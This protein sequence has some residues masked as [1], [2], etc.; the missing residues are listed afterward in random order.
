MSRL[1]NDVSGFWRTHV[2]YALK[3]LTVSAVVQRRI[4]V[5]AHPRC[6]R[7]QEAHG[8]GGCSTTY[9]GSGA[10]TLPTPSRVSRCRRLFNDVSGF[11]R[12]HVAHALKGLGV[13]QLF[14][15]VGV[16]W[17]GVT[18]YA[19]RAHGVAVVRQRP[20]CM[21]SMD[22]S[23]PWIAQGVGDGGFNNHPGSIG[24]A[25]KFLRNL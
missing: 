3:R 9:L 14:D 25:K 21:F 2:A 24:D 6:P 10:P 15:N 8:V 16:W 11:W 13:S 19:A 1:F 12:T 5:L 4:W 17:P 18:T 22:H 7:P 20:G 23:V